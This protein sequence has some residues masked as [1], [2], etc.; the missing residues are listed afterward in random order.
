MRVDSQRSVGSNS[1]NSSFS[2]S[3]TLRLCPRRPSRSGGGLGALSS[4]SRNSA[5]ASAALI[6]TEACKLMSSMLIAPDP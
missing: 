6:N 3:A 5:P 2:R 1:R 4:A